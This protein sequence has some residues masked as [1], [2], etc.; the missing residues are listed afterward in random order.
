MKA[1]EMKSDF[2]ISWFLLIS[3]GLIWGMAFMGVELALRNFQ[4]LTI[5]AIRISLAALILNLI[6]FFTGNKLPK[7][8]DT[9]GKK[10]MMHCLGMALLSNA[11]PFSLLS[12]AQIK[13][14]SGFAG[15]AMAVVPLVVLPMTHF[16]C[17]KCKI[18]YLFI[19]FAI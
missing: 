13:V 5:A 8:S 7:L 14:S 9:N 1:K 16:C 18:N 2:F 15:I 12:W 4:P 17:G 6:G 3:L 19:C 10:I 11:L